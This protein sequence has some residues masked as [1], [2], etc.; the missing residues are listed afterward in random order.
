MLVGAG[1]TA[2]AVGSVRLP[3][4]D[5]ASAVCGVGD[6]LTQTIVLNLRLPRVLLAILI[7]VALGTSGAAYQALF[8]N[9]LADPF[10]IGAS[11]GAAAAPPW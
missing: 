9:P 4:T 2:L 5:V 10:V 8:R 1:L 11:S 6:P 3:I 7:G